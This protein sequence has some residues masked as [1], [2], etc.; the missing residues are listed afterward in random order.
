MQGDHCSETAAARSQIN[1]A[2]AKEVGVDGSLRC[3][4]ICQHEANDL[5]AILGV[6]VRHQRDD[7]MLKVTDGYK[8]EMR[9]HVQLVKL[10]VSKVAKLHTQ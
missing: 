9:Q 5:E 3:S 8:L 1:E 4:V 7:G 6:V 2:Q 10:P